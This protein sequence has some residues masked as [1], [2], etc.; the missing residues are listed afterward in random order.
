MRIEKSY[1][2]VINGN[3]VPN[4]RIASRMIGMKYT[5]LYNRVMRNNNYLDAVI[6]GFSITIKE[7]KEI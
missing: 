3:A 7:F 1:T 5:T 2:V 6:N 4:M